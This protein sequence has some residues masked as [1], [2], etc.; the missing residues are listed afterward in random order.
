MDRAAPV[1]GPYDFEPVGPSD[2]DQPAGELAGA[3]PLVDDRQ[4]G[5]AARLDRARGFTVCGHATHRPDLV[6]V[7][8]EG[9]R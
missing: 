3:V 9:V 5:T 4:P 6:V 7:A 8:D 2:D 1:V